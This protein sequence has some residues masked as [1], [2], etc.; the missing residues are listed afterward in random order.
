MK[1]LKTI[2][3]TTVFWLLVLLVIFGYAK[4]T[5]QGENLANNIAK[6]LGVVPAIETTVGSGTLTD[7]AIMTQF[8][9][10]QDAIEKMQMQLDVLVSEDMLEDN[11]SSDVTTIIKEDI[12]I[13]KTDTDADSS[14]VTDEDV[15]VEATTST[16][17]A[18]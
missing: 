9:Q 7:E 16:G 14:T 17:T 3:W 10:I 1:I 18:E 13:E 12:T 5:K 6:N 15:E 8:T 2:F 4:Y 11:I